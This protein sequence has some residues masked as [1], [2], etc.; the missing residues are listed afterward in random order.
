M[1]PIK[2]LQRELPNNRSVAVF[3]FEDGGYG[4]KFTN[5]GEE[6]HLALSREAM[7]SLLQIVGEIERGALAD[8]DGINKSIG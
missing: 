2:G 4:L 5:S 1:D 6:T 8:K 7:A 3:P